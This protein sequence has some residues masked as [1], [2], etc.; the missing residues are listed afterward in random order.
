[1]K[2]G[3][4]TFNGWSKLWRIIAVPYW[5]HQVRNFEHSLNIFM[6][7]HISSWL[8]S[9]FFVWT[10]ILLF[11][12]MFSRPLERSSCKSISF[13]HF[14]PHELL[15]YGCFLW[16]TVSLTELSLYV[17]SYLFVVHKLCV[18]SSWLLLS[19]LCMTSIV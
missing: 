18:S 10:K 9:Y 17:E 14:L 1:M 4:V 5:I 13:L 6:F 11:L 19:F 16:I 3:F 12:V 8:L 15:S 2:F 7:W